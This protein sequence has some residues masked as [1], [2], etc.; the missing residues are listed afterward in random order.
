MDFG[1]R[2]PSIKYLDDKYF[3][4]RKQAFRNGFVIEE[5]HSF[6]HPNF[7]LLF[8]DFNLKKVFFLVGLRLKY[9]DWQVMPIEDEDRIHIEIR[10]I[11]TK[12]KSEIVVR[13]TFLSDF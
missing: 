12:G 6:D 10:D 1:T 2:L 4:D 3:G 9:N 11:V 5:W 7:S 8:F 13:K